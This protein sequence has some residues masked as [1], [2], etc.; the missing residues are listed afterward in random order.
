MGKKILW[1]DNDR[2][3]LRPII[4]VLRLKGFEVIQAVT[5]RNAEEAMDA[6]PQ[7]DLLIL[8]VM[9][10]VRPGEEDIIDPD[11]TSLG[12]KT[13]LLFYQ[14]FKSHFEKGGT[15][16]LVCTL[17]EDTKL[18]KECESAGLPVNRFITKSEMA[19]IESFVRTITEIVGG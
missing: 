4:E 17:R 18:R 6:W 5:L 11:E 16:V 9:I 15:K 8:D 14:K 2:V 12:Q 1:L 19:N 10:P 7:P 3:F 13:G